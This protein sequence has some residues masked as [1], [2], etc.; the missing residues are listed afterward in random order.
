MTDLA[1][2]ARVAAGDH[3]LCVI[4]TTR[5]DGTVQASLVNAGVLDGAVV[6]VAAGNARK[7]THL[8]ARSAITIVARQSWNWAAV[9]GTATLVG[10]D[11]PAD[12]VDAEA[13]RVMLRDAFKAAGGQHGDW[14][15]YD[16]VMREER[17]VVVRVEP[18]RVYSNG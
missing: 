1:D 7:L 15:T 13:L 9:E 8:R 10:P 2:F 11:D 12:G 16:R 5:A 4:A 3:N 17:R 14:D 18:T 6:F